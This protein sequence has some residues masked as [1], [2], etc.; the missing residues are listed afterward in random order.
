VTVTRAQYLGTLECYDD[1]KLEK[2]LRRAYA[3][4]TFE[5]EHYWKR[6][7]FF[8]G[9]QAAIFV[10]F[11]F[12][13]KEPGG[14]KQSGFLVLALSSLGIL[15]AI[16]NHLSTRGSKFWQE[17]WEKHIDMLEDAVEGRLY[18]TVWLSDGVREY[19]VS[20][21]NLTLSRFVAGMPSSLTRLS[22]AD[23]DF[24]ISHQG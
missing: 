3:Q 10:A 20:G 15:T 4:R 22:G 9:F 18:K 7:T 8:W 1:S 11:G 14:P 2:A 6:A 5:I 12:V 19:S 16:A 21:V 24:R 13:W 17:N 23:S